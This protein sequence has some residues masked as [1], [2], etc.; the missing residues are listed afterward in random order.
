MSDCHSCAE[1]SRSQ[2]L[3]RGLAKAGQ[4]L[5][6]IEPGMPVPTVLVVAPPPLVNPRGA[7]AAKF[8]NADRKCGGMAE[9][10]AAVSEREGCAFFDAGTVTSTSP[11]DG[12]HL[13]AD[14]HLLLGRALAPFVAGILA[15]SA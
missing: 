2:L 1:F 10:F 9:A 8:R 6:P 5:P 3:R 4:G 15:R 7:I 13:D 14:Q 11:V 12:V